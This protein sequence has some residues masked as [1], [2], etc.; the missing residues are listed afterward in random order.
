M[1][2][3][4]MYEI[5]IEASQGQGAVRTKE[6]VIASFSSTQSKVRRQYLK[7]MSQ[8]MSIRLLGSRY[9]GVVCL[10]EENNVNKTK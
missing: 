10:L 1:K 5:E 8:Q 3:A 7:E 6:I 9:V 2:T 4:K